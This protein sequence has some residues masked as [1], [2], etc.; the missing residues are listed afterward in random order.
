[1]NEDT[2]RAVVD[3]ITE[4]VPHVAVLGTYGMLPHL[5]TDIP[6]LGYPEQSPSLNILVNT[7]SGAGP[8][9]E[10][11]LEDFYANLDHAMENATH[12]LVLDD[13]QM[14]T[15]GTKPMRHRYTMTLGFTT[16]TTGKA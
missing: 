11:A 14:S 3:Y 1:M 2:R 6:V 15:S 16:T 13:L 12:G 9:Q 5:C 7:I 10:Q 4:K 8:T